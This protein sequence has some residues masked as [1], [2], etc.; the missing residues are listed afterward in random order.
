MMPKK[1]IVDILTNK[2]KEIQD[3]PFDSHLLSE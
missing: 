2:E 1:K 3:N